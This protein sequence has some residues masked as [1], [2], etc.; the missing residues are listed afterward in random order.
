LINLRENVLGI[1]LKILSIFKK[2][3]QPPVSIDE[4]RWRYHAEEFFHLPG[5]AASRFGLEE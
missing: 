2:P 3:T 5:K 4:K 1:F